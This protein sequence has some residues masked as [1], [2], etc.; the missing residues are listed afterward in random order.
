[1]CFEGKTD[2]SLRYVC[3]MFVVGAD[4]CNFKTSDFEVIR[5]YMKAI[6]R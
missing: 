6:P 2:F 4:F 5:E 1:M 3:D